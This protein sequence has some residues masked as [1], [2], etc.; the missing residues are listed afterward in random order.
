MD[1]SQPINVKDYF[2][3]YAPQLVEKIKQMAARKRKSPSRSP[4]R[5]RSRSPKRSP[6]RSPRRR[7]RSPSMSPGGKKAARILSQMKK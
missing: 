7:A 2:Q 3:K 5:S 6:K 1:P 4:K